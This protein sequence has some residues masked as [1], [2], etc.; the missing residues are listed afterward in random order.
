MSLNLGGRPSVSLSL[1]VVGH[2]PMGHPIVHHVVR[3]PRHLSK[4]IHAKAHAILELIV[5]KHGLEVAAAILA[6]LGVV[7]RQAPIV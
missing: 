7:H 6:F 2:P 3:V 1:I 5:A 4:L